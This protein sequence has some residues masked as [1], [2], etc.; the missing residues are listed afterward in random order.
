MKKLLLALLALGLF[1]A[2]AF[3]GGWTL[4][5]QL[6]AYGQA[7]TVPAGTQTLIQSGG[8]PSDPAVANGGMYYLQI[9]FWGVIDIG[10]TAPTELQ[11]SVDPGING[12]ENG[13]A[14]PIMTYG[15]ASYGPTPPGM[16]AGNK[17]FLEGATWNVPTN[18]SPSSGITGLDLNAGDTINPALYLTST[19][20]SVTVESGAV[21]TW[22]LFYAG[23]KQ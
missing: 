4:M 20:A 8:S 19:G 9:S 11:F 17:L 14:Q 23:P 1:S 7:T 15:N 21:M 5:D 16:K 10:S 6:G 2:P 13:T 3:A 18:V 22:T 12:F